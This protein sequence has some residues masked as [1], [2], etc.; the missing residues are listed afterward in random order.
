MCCGYNRLRWVIAKSCTPVGFTYVTA[1]VFFYFGIMYG[2][3]LKL[4]SSASNS[5]AVPPVMSLVHP[6]ILILDRAK[7]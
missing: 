7:Q 3:K 4:V 6:G 2:T 5:L 1:V